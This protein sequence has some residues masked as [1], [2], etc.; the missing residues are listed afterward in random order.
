MNAAYRQTIIFRLINYLARN[1]EITRSIKSISIYEYSYRNS[2]SHNY[3]LDKKVDNTISTM[4]RIFFSY[5][6]KDE[7]TKFVVFHFIPEITITNLFENILIGGGVFDFI[8]GTIKKNIN[9]VSKY[10]YYF[11]IKA[12]TNNSV[13][14]KISLDTYSDILDS[15]TIN[16]YPERDLD[17]SLEKTT[18]NVKAEKSENIV[19]SIDNYK[20]I[21]QFTNYICFSINPKNDAICNIQINVTDPP[22]HIPDPVPEPEEQEKSD[23]PKN[24]DEK[25]DKSKDS[26]EISN[27][28]NDSF[29]SKNKLFIGIVA[30]SIFIV[31]IF[32][33]VC[34]ILRKRNKLKSTDLNDM[35]YSPIQPNQLNELK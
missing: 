33:I 35:E 25:P 12:K 17:N 34:L 1:D 22:P 27:K 28:T 7:N 9:L 11:F 21:S 16:E 10:D 30:G 32:I 2:S 19:F 4:S 3:Y 20:V 15:I 6:I 8:N 14:I 23:E 5:E 29:F 13:S 24:S 26:G 31:L 18:K